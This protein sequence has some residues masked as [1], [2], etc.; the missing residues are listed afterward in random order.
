M[1][2]GGKAM[3]PRLVKEGKREMISGGQMLQRLRKQLLEA[4]NTEVS[5]NPHKFVC[6]ESK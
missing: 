3:R 5:Q 6:V 2:Y 4:I 1:E